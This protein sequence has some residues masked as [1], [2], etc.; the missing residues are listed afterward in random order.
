[1]IAVVENVESAVACAVLCNDAGEV[2][3]SFWYGGSR[4]KC[5]LF[6]SDGVLADINDATA[7]YYLRGDTCREGTTTPT[8]TTPTMATVASECFNGTPMKEAF[9]FHGSTPSDHICKEMCGAGTIDGGGRIIARKKVC[10]V[11]YGD[12]L[13][14]PG[15]DR[16]DRRDDSREGSDVVYDDDG[17]NDNDNDNDNDDDD[18]VDDDDDDGGDGDCDNEEPFV[19]HQVCARITILTT[20][21]TSATP[22]T[23]APLPTPSPTTLELGKYLEDPGDGYTDQDATTTTA[24]GTTS[25]KG[26]VGKVVGNPNPS[27]SQVLGT[28]SNA[29][30][31]STDGHDSRGDG[32]GGDDGGD[33]SQRAASNGGLVAALICLFAILVIVAAVVMVKKRSSSARGPDAAH[34]DGPERDVGAVAIPQYAAPVM[35]LDNIV[36]A[37]ATTST[38]VNPTFVIGT[39]APNPASIDCLQAD[40]YQPVVYAAVKSAEY[41]APNA[42]QPSLYDDANDDSTSSTPA[43][44]AATA[45]SN[46]NGSSSG[47]NPGENHYYLE[48]Q[49]QYATVD[50][51]VQV[52]GN[53]YCEVMEQ[54]SHPVRGGGGEDAPAYLEP[55]PLATRDQHAP[56]YADLA[57]SEYC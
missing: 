10:K 8:T 23:T 13:T 41:R 14:G 34:P 33:A 42:A 45:A 53:E 30:N 57:A 43:T 56:V 2:C 15:G 52:G 55:T 39:A 46:T 38:V 3:V 29:T 12:K 4:E 6:P 48:P 35:Q 36:H 17:D 54:E 49:E 25:V 44:A 22:P 37:A 51:C 16:R 7:G 19:V 27:V 50:N 11:W 32:D 9:Y 26:G 5:R 40:C 31:T 24:A 21:T 47:S 28:S 18:E 1:M 20:T